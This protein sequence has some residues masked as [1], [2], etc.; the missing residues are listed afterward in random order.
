MFWV[1]AGSLTVET[2]DRAVTLGEGE[3]LVIPAGVEHHSRA[4]APARVLFLH[5]NTT[6]LP[7][8]ARD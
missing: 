4:A 6:K 7:A 3:M 1:A 2:R 5:R 8:A